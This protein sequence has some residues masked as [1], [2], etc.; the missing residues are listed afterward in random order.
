MKAGVNR[1]ESAGPETIAMR[2]AAALLTLALAAPAAAQDRTPDERQTLLELAR[3][4]GEAHALRL[5]CRGAADQRWRNRMQRIVE[6]EAA[7]EAF[8]ARLNEA[9]NTGYLTAEAEHPECDAGTSRAVAR[10]ADRG[11]GLAQKLAGG[12]A[13]AASR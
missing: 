2:A 12:G 1:S 6:L 4:L 9:F 10:A 3:T 8:K 13:E 5:A 11:R 7:D